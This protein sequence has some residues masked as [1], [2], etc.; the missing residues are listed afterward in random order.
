MQGEDSRV[1]DGSPENI[2]L[3][4][5]REEPVNEP[6]MKQQREQEAERSLGDKGDKPDVTC[7]PLPT[8]NDK[9]LPKQINTK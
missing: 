6:E 5:Q 7:S 9:K 8:S 2:H 1:E 4:R 3:I